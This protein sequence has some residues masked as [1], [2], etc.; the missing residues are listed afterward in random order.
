M[1][2]D[3]GTDKNKRQREGLAIAKNLR[4]TVRSV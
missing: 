2:H 1:Y 4:A 3:R